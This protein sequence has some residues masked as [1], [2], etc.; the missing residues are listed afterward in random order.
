MRAMTTEMTP[1]SSGPNLNAAP[2]DPDFPTMEQMLAMR[3]VDRLPLLCKQWASQVS[4]TPFSI[5]ALYWTKYFVLFIGG[6][7]FFASF[8]K[9]YAGLWTFDWFFS[10]ASFQKAVVWCMFYE[11][12]GFGC[13]SGPMNGKFKPPIG[14][15]LYFARPGTTKL[16]LVPDWPI[17]GGI[18]RSWFDV[19]GYV[20][21]MIF[22]FRALIAPEVTPELLAPIFVL[23][24]I[25]GLMDKTLFLAARAEHYYTALVVLAVASG[26]DGLWIAG[27]KMIWMF[28]WFWAAM[29][30]VN[31]HFGSV[32]MVMMNNGPFFPK[33]LKKRLFTDYPEDLRPSPFAHRM[34]H[35]GAATEA[36]IPVLFLLFGGDP[37]AAFAIAFLATGFHGFIALNNPSGMPI[38]WNIMMIYGA[39]FLFFANPE[40]S[41]GA[42]PEAMPLLFL[43]LLFALLVVPA[44]GNFFPR[45][46]SFLLAMRYYAGNW[47]Y[48]LWLFRGDAIEKLKRCTKA[49]GTLGEQLES[50]GVDSLGVRA[51]EINAATSRFLHLQGRVLHD[52]VPHAVDDADNYTWLDGE[53]VAGMVVGWNFGDGHLG[54]E[55]LARV[56][57]PQCQFEPGEVRVISVE[58]QPLF[59]PTMAWRTFDVATGPIAEGET[60]MF[61][62][63][64]WQ[65]WPEGERAEA[66]HNG[67]APAS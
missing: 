31:H 53:M 20:A 15:F 64:E 29:S 49:S 62:A 1:P 60:R 10:W 27:C 57:Q 43:F 46:V 28:I 40:I 25:L 59:G 36:S 8:A 33:W 56:L 6:W 14:G 50:M 2:E 11:L 4:A 30:K 3:F 34:A 12:A 39:W 61:P 32:I 52:A 45:H 19:A 9:G 13:S 23:L 37:L 24:P 44:Y 26:D 38:E 35:F 17:L 21:M 42:L 66:F 18:T 41:V 54:H 47:A 22:L 5:I 67:H 65:P 63:Q 7:A 51:A 48:N 16:S 58:G 55:S